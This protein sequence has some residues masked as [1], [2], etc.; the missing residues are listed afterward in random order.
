MAFFNNKIVWITGASS[1]IGEALSY[2]FARQGAKLVISSRRQKELQRVKSNCP[3]PENVLILPIDLEKHDQM[4]KKVQTVLKHFGRIDVLVNNGGIS[5]RSLAK[6]TDLYVDKKIMDI[7]YFGTIALT[8]ALLPTLIEQ[9]SGQ[10]A[11][12]SSVTGKIGVPVRS[13]YA[14]SKHALFGFFD[15]LR[16]EHWQDKIKVCMICP[17]Y[18]RTNVSINALT[19]K[20]APQNT[21]D[22]ATDKGMTPAELSKKI[23]KA[24]KKGKKEV[25]FGGKEVAGIYL[26]RFL[27]G[28]LFRIMRK[29]K[30]T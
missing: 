9:K 1:G 28:L 18:I 16:A 17:G 21:M 3:T 10:I 12:I 7:N 14:A 23:L 20:G 30:V 13:A 5:Q 25:Y 6:D 26:R 29:A 15:S 24:L 19:G 4:P 22:E 11:V 27:P 8:K 2:A